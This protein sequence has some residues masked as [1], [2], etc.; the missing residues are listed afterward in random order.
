[1]SVQVFH[2][3]A[4]SADGSVADPKTMFA[5][6][7]D[8]EYTDGV[9]NNTWSMMENVNEVCTPQQF[10]PGTEKSFETSTLSW[11]ARRRRILLLM[12]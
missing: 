2:G 8:F 1:M 9:F 5:F 11:S 6:F 12:E 3:S 10:F 4:T 7:E